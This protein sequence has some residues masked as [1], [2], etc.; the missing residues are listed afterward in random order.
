MIIILCCTIKCPVC[1]GNGLFIGYFCPLCNGDGIISRQTEVNMA[2]YQDLKCPEC[3]ARKN[4][5]LCFGRGL[6]SREKALN[7]TRHRP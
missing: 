7:L 5:C 6:I 3:N 4:C 2:D 1:E